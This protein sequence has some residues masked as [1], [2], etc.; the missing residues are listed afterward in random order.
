MIGVNINTFDSAFSSEPNTILF[1]G[2]DDECYVHYYIQQ[3]LDRSG[4]IL[5]Y[6]CSGAEAADDGSEVR[7]Q[8]SRCW[9]APVNQTIVGGACGRVTSHWDQLELRERF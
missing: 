1:S 3:H 4:V 6:I 8:R 7:H 9:N 2:S 5:I